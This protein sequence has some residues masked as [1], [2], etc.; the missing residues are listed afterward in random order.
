MQDGEKRPML[1]HE[2]EE[3]FSSYEVKFPK[4]F[5]DDYLET[6][7]FKKISSGL[8]ENYILTVAWRI[9]WDELYRLH[10]F[11]DH[12]SRS[13]FEEFCADLKRAQIIYRKKR[14]F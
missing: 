8:V 6:N 7:K 12:F 3:L 1:C 9:L 11:T 5:L 13:I 4:I 10:S 2:C 14:Y